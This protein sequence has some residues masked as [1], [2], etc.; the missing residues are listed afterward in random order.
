MN[1]AAM[2]NEKAEPKELGGVLEPRN[3]VS[4]DQVPGPSLQAHHRGRAGRNDYP[5]KVSEQ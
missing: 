5:K 4:R 3:Q 2:A 1:A